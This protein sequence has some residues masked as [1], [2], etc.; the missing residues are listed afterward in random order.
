MKQII[1]IFFLF[2][3]VLFAQKNYAQTANLCQPY[4]IPIGAPIACGDGYVGYKFAMKTKTCPD[5]RVTEG[6]SFN[7]DGCR[8]I[9][10]IKDPNALNCNITPNALGCVSTPSMK[11]C[12]AGKHWTTQ[13]SGI[14]HCVQDDYNCPWG[15]Q[16][17]R[18]SLGNPSCQPIICPSNQVLQGDGVTCGCSA[19][20]G[21]NG[22][23]C[24]PLCT[25]TTQQET[26]SCTGGQTGTMTRDV[27]VKCD[28]QRI[29]SA[30][31][32]S[33][34][35]APPVVCPQP[36]NQ[37]RSCQTGYSGT[38]TFTTNYSGPLCTPS[39]NDDSA[40]QCQVIPPQPITC[41]NPNVSS[42]EC[43][44]GYTGAVIN[45]VSYT[46]S[47]NGQTCIANTLEDRTQCKVMCTPS[48]ITTQET[49]ACEAGNIGIQKRDVTTNSC[50]G[51][52]TY[53]KWQSS[54]VPEPQPP[55]INYIDEDRWFRA[56]VGKACSL[57]KWR[58]GYQNGVK[59]SSELLSTTNGYIG[60]LGMCVLEHDVGDPP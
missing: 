7:T 38:Y 49:A 31:N 8:R 10:D 22:A 4:S 33:T 20:M 16:L 26:A 52:V 14:A 1:K 53:G 30:W 23:S 13:G 6:Q 12:D 17:K 51:V 32:T 46:P 15:Q 41:P 3:L 36:L 48:F 24:V 18:D 60:A 9:S 44:G 35:V 54:C 27:L 47:Q 58:F 59:V 2:F 11:G 50:S 56:A 21:W 43:G 37:T 34:C 45:T 25:D 40:S 42:F 5:G 55:V 28:G 57:Q 39:H 29:P 19:G